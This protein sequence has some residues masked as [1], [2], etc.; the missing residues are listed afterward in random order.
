MLSNANLRGT[1][2][3]LI[4]K[5][6]FTPEFLEKTEKVDAIILG[7][8][9]YFF[10]V[11]GEMKS[12]MERLMYPYLTYTDP[13]KSLFH[14]KI[15][16]GIIYTMNV[17]ET[18]MKEYGFG[19]HFN[20][21]EMFLQMIFGISESFYSYDTYQFT[22]YSKMGGNRFDP[23]KKIKRREEVFPKDCENA[24]KMGARFAKK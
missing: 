4:E 10:D 20:V 22:D 12:F 8:P 16:T 9:V 11:S 7:S 2:L 15:N 5:E 19:Q 18:Q 1:I 13:P 23:E 6:H 17:T 14:K 3:N 21:I 24:F